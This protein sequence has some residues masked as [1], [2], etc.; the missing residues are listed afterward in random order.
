MYSNINLKLLSGKDTQKVRDS[1]RNIRQLAMYW[2]KN[3]SDF[4]RGESMLD[5]CSWSVLRL[6]T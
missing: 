3:E 4:F 1:E 6:H 5:F 2:Q